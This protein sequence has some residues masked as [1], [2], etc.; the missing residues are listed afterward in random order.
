MLSR[1]LR[2]QYVV[3][4][5]ALKSPKR[6]PPLYL[7]TLLGARIY[8]ARLA[9]PFIAFLLLLSINHRCSASF[10]F[11]FSPLALEPPPAEILLLRWAALQHRARGAESLGGAVSA[12]DRPV[13]VARLLGFH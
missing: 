8:S 12:D 4:G 10:F 11:F 2:R 9:P 5:D 7:H 13:S 1:R 6:I 3:V